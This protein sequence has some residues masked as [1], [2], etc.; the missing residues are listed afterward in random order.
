MQQ[1]KLSEGEIERIAADAVSGFRPIG[2][3][4]T[5]AEFA[6]AAAAAAIKAL[7]KATGGRV[8][9]VQDDV[10]ALLDR[11]SMDEV[12]L[13]GRVVFATDGSGRVGVLQSAGDDWGDCVGVQFMLEGSVGWYQLALSPARARILAR[14][15]VLAA[16]HREESGNPGMNNIDHAPHRAPALSLSGGNR[17]PSTST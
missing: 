5:T 14:H 3:D 7:V 13:D 12:T 15:L 1:A 17:T 6:V 4:E 16:E 11:A 8:I 10:P 9:G 2:T